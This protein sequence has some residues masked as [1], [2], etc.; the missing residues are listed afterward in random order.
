MDVD[1]IR[2]AY[3]VNFLTSIKHNDDNDND[4]ETTKVKMSSKL[5]S[6]K[7]KRRKS[8]ME[9]RR[10][11]EER[12]LKVRGAKRSGVPLHNPGVLTQAA[13]LFPQP[14]QTTLTQLQEEGVWYDRIE[15]KS[16]KND[17]ST[18]SPKKKHSNDGR[19]RE[20]Q[21]EEFK[22]IALGQTTSPEKKDNNKR[23][24]LLSDINDDEDFEPK[25]K[26]SPP[27][28]QKSSK[29]TGVVPV[30]PSKTAGKS[31]SGYCCY[32][33][34]ATQHCHEKLFGRSSFEEAKLLM[35]DEGVTNITLQEVIQRYRT[36]YKSN[37]RFH[38]FNQFNR[39]PDDGEFKGILPL[40]MAEISYK[41]TISYY[42]SR[43][44]F[45]CHETVGETID[46]SYEYNGTNRISKIG[47]KSS[48]YEGG[49]EEE[50]V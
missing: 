14:E 41:D 34:K 48:K 17:T 39:L 1:N 10:E 46:I 49:V 37:F 7:T 47:K 43:I 3:I 13:F 16:R 27:K 33:H 28:K 19:D 40:C 36:V 9:Q 15:P 42:S 12:R 35:S 11:A 24:H 5:S 22:R 44:S 30:T 2:D 21:L 4:I 50:S 38:F 25:Y 31:K 8:K 6:S 23:S 18:K 29:S 32:C 26:P 20:A 45:E